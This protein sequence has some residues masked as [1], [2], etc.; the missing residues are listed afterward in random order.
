MRK[1]K[2]S[3]LGPSRAVRTIPITAAELVRDRRPLIP[4]E[5]AL[6][7]LAT[8]LLNA[9]SG[10]E[11]AAWTSW[12]LRDQPDTSGFS[13]WEAPV[14]D[15]ETCSGGGVGFPEAPADTTPI[16]MDDITSAAA[17]G[18]PYDPGA[19]GPARSWVA[20]VAGV[21]LDT[22]DVSAGASPDGSPT[23]PPDYAS[24]TTLPAF[25][26]SD[27]HDA[28]ALHP[29]ARVDA[30]SD[31]VVAPAPS[32]DPDDF[33]TRLERPDRTA[34]ARAGGAGARTARAPGH[35]CVVRRATERSAPSRAHERG[36]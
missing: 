26:P 24:F 34:R 11:P 3:P 13:Y 32:I 30:R 12:A 1:R 23:P 5:P 17:A 36:R 29:S 16:T 10:S 19:R 33:T 25:E 9:G 18:W 6:V 31:I 28:M 4:L 14:V 35:G 2:Q 8:G 21:G 7:D 27:V 20:M 22:D 15:G